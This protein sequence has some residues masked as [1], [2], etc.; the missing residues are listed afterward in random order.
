MNGS[1]FA[2]SDVWNFMFSRICQGFFIFYL[3]CSHEVHWPS[4]LKSVIFGQ[5]LFG[6]GAFEA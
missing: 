5:L 4:V 3:T 1:H 2:C 6:F